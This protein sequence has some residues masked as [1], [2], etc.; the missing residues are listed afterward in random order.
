MK[1][2]TG[3]VSNSS[4]SSFLFVFPKDAQIEGLMTLEEWAEREADP[5]RDYWSG[6]ESAEVVLENHY[7]VDKIRKSVGDD[8]KFIEVRVS[9]SDGFESAERI[10]KAVGAKTVILPD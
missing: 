10:A 6:Y 7:W 8:E 1:I 9:W 5:D 3:F 2:R 4:S